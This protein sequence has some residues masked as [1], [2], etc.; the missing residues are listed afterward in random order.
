MLGKT[1]AMEGKRKA[2]GEQKNKNTAE[3]MGYY[4]DELRN[5]CEFGRGKQGDRDREAGQDSGVPQG[6]KV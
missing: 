3:Q 5:E 2:E 4:S 1:R 6:R